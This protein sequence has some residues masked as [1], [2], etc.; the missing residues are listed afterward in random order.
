MS[1]LRIIF[2]GSPDFAVPVLASLIDAGHQIVCVYAQPPR[3]AG[4]GQKEQPCPVHK[5]AQE[6]NLTVRTPK[7]F[8]DDTAQQEFAAF[9]ADVAV[10]AAYG[11]ILPKAVLAAPRFGCVNVHASLLPRW[12]GAAPIHRAIL[13]GDTE[14]GITIMAMDEGLDT[15]AMIRRQAVPITPTTTAEDLHDALAA[16]GATMIV[17]ALDDLGAGNVTPE[18]Q[19]D[20][21]VT[22]AKK[23]ER[24]EGRLDWTQPADYLE[25]AVRAFN[26]WPG[27]W[28]ILPGNEKNARVK[29]LAAKVVHDNKGKE[30]GTV[31]D[32]T[33]AI[34]C[35]FG[36]LRLERLQRAGK[37][38]MDTGEFLRGTQLPAGTQLPIDDKL[39]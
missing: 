2:M 19:P 36:A 4:R 23:L 22:Y 30:P 20:D 16:L 18:P 32:D 26:P 9:K 1:N 13:S 15:G 5:Y 37:A 8:K 3:P 25:R 17:T 6:K 7:S 28:F 27:T 33:L 38:A 24:R 39:D 14:S 12:R 29:V 11:L 10:V 31:I 35:G 21:G 34:A